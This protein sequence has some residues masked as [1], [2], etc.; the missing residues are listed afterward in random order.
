MNTAESMYTS[1]KNEVVC[2]DDTVPKPVDTRRHCEE[3]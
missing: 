3:E 1:I 2:R